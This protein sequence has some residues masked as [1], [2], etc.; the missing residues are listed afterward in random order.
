MAMP[1][2]RF[3]GM[4][5]MVLSRLFQRCEPASRWHL[6]RWIAIATVLLLDLIHG[7][8]PVTAQSD[9]VRL[10]VP[11]ARIGLGGHVRPVTWTPLQLL[12]TNQQLTH[13]VVS[14]RWLIQ[15]QDGDTIMSQRQV[16]L[17]P[18]RTEHVWLYG[19]PPLSTR[20]G[21]RWMIQVVQEN[22]PQ[23]L[24]AEQVHL[25]ANNWIPPDVG[26]VGVFSNSDLGLSPHLDP[27]TLTQHEQVVALRGLT[28]QWLPDRWFGLSVMQAMIWAADG[29]NP[30]GSNVRPE[31]LQA[32]RQ[33]VHRGGHLV[34]FLP[35]IGEPWTDSALADLLPVSSTQMRR[36]DGMPPRIAGQLP[37]EQAPLTPIRMTIFDVGSNVPVLARTR[38]GDPLII[39]DRYGFGSV[40]L[41]GLD[42]ADDRIK[43]LGYPGTNVHEG[44]WHTIFQWQGPIYKPDEV[45]H[46]IANGT[47]SRPDLRDPKNLTS[48]IDALV[49]QTGTAAAGLL[50]AILIFGLYW[51]LAGPVSYFGLKQYKAMRYSWLVFTATIFL[52]T[53]VAWSGAFIMHPVTTTIKHFSICDVDVKRGIVRT[54]A[55]PSLYV[56]RFDRIKVALK[57]SEDP[58]GCNT[59]ASPGIRLTLAD[60]GFLDP[61]SYVVDCARPESAQVPFRS[62]TKNFEIDYL[63]PISALGPDWPAPQGQ[64]QLKNFW[65]EGQLSHDLPGPLRD[66][67]F[68]YCTG[69][70]A[71]STNQAPWVWRLDK[72]WDP[73]TTLKI[74]IPKPQALALVKRPKGNWSNRQWKNEGYLGDL[75]DRKT[76]HT[77][78][79]A[80]NDLIQ[81]MDMLSFFN[82]LP[83][84]D[85]RNGNVLPG[86]TTYRRTLGRAMD[87]TSLTN[88]KRLIIIGHLEDQP[89]PVPLTVDGKYLE[90]RGWTVVRWI[91][92]L[93]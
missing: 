46:R 79:S 67:L 29:G 30:N 80:V 92:D 10:E 66:V 1:G 77:Q 19:N 20:P 88:G 62:T 57:P 22:P 48:S 50:A 5:L 42:L 2:T 13:K 58:G 90:S 32:I 86:P 85:F 15:D 43:R 54:L 44:I 71:D 16:T 37:G 64:L 24:A 84:P 78:V 73:G 47:H 25:V 31:V 63:G 4:S 9:A 55:W 45:K 11:R 27:R 68:V 14:C 81:R 8:L 41:I 35:L 76:A 75:I 6:E 52:F 91:Y 34:I 23:V 3:C 51:I 70:Q 17:N 56:P 26:V 65:P 21:Q 82:Y 36:V 69:R 87:L 93:D 38:D 49:A 60:E 74:Q 28:L 33:W 12:I 61:Q 39:S 89:L 7:G 72:P 83:P 59:L 18:Q 40:T 53:I